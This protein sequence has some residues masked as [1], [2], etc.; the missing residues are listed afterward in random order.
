MAYK[1]NKGKE[2][3]FVSARIF[4]GKKIYY[5]ALGEA[6]QEELEELFAI[7]PQYITKSKTTK[8]KKKK[9]DNDPDKPLPTPPKVDEPED[10]TKD[11]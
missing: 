1:V 3:L 7:L 10:T 8:R 6:T 2:K 9:R 11:V 5:G 4:D